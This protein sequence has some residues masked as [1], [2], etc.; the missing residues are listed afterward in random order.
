MKKVFLF[1]IL[2]NCIAYSQTTKNELLNEI[3]SYKKSKL[4]NFQF[5]TNFK[6]LFDAISIMGN[7]NF[8]SPSKESETRGYIEFKKESESKKENLTIEIRGENKPYRLSIN[9][10]IETR[11]TLYKNQGTLGQPDFKV[12][13]EK[14]D[15]TENQFNA[16]DINVSVN[17]KIYKILFKEFVLPIEI[18]DKIKNFNLSQKK[19]RKKILQGVDFEL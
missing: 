5:H 13:I 3:E 15:W 19:D 16:E 8:G 14:G 18:Q 10:K 9:Y 2:I 11:A 4:L 7:Q 12:V 6:E 1:L 17:L